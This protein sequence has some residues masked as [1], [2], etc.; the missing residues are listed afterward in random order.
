MPLSPSTGLYSTVTSLGSILADMAAAL[1]ALFQGNQPTPKTVT[2]T[3]Y[4]QLVT[5][6]TLIFNASGTLTLTLLSASAIPGKI[7]LLTNIAN[8]AINSASSNVIPLG[9]GA[10]GTSVLGATAGKFAWL[11]SIGTNWQI[12]ASN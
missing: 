3:T 2:G 5:D 4:A 10:A 1:T 8:N 9:G 11:Q 7:I 6:G 12:M